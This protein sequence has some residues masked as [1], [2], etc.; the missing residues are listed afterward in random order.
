MHSVQGGGLPD[1]FLLVFCFIL[2]DLFCKFRY[3]NY[4][5]FQA[6]N[7]VAVIVQRRF[8]IAKVKIIRNKK[9][10]QYYATLLKRTLSLA[11]V[12]KY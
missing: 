3:C 8:Q 7:Q 1:I 6:S 5:T 10:L 11:V 9:M 4:E 2:A 12:S